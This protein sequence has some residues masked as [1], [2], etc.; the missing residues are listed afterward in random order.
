MNLKD[1]FLW[2]LAFIWTNILPLLLVVG[3]CIGVFF[4]L[5]YVQNLS[6]ALSLII[7]I[8]GGAGLIFGFG[9]LLQKW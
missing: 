3:F 4:N 5:A 7:T 2:I 8:V 9:K 6:F 1:K